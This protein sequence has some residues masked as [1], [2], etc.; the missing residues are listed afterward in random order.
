[1]KAGGYIRTPRFST[2]KLKEV[3]KTRLEAYMAGYRETTHYS[4]SCGREVWGRSI[5]LYHMEFVGVDPSLMDC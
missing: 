3:Y 2:V 4:D 5:D 1:M